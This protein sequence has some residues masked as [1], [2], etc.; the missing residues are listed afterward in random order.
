LGSGASAQTC[1]ASTAVDGSARCAIDPVNQAL[2]P[3]Q[4]SASFG[5]DGFYMAASTSA[6]ALVFEYATGGTFVLGDGSA[7]VGS[8]ETFWADTWSS[9]NTLSGGA[10]PSSFKG[11]ANTPSST[12]PVCGGT[13]TSDPGNS[14]G[15]PPAPLPGYMA[16]VVSSAVSKSSSTITGNI[17]QIVIVKTDAGYAPDPQFHGTGTVVAVLC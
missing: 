2:G 4:A 7:G 8:S 1:S 17:T 16:V 13:W 10:G 14:S 9:E 11:F 5:G 3:G 12:P 15:P 6:S